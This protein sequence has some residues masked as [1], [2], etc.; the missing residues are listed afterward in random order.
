MMR[1]RCLR[2]LMGTQ[3]LFTA[4][5]PSPPVRVRRASPSSLEVCQPAA[6]DEQR[7]SA[8]LDRDDGAVNSDDANAPWREVWLSPTTADGHDAPPPAASLRRGATV[9]VLPDVAS[10]A[11]RCAL[12]DAAL[13]AT[14]AERAPR[15]AGAL[16][17][18][19]LMRLT[20]DSDLPRDAAAVCDAVLRRVLDRLDAQLPSIAEAY[21]PTDEGEDVPPGFG[22]ES[23]HAAGASRATSGRRRGRS[24]GAMFEADAVEFAFR[25]P[26][27][28]VY[29]AGGEFKPHV[30]G[31]ALTV[32]VPLNA[33]G[34]DYLGGGTGFWWTPPASD[35]SGEE[36]REEE[37][38]T[39]RGTTAPRTAPRPAARSSTAARDKPPTRVLRPPPGTAMVFDGQEV[40]HAGMP[41]ESGTRVLF[42][43]S[44][45]ARGAPE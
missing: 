12:V 35:Q 1:S 22:E 18:A 2:C 13:C 8:I 37:E 44:F 23:A 33:P 41:T 19:T 38:D 34:D 43:A 14:A 4:A 6:A 40:W 45:R 20:R 30:D 26:A 39:R 29:V 5:F 36:L 15:A 24:L 32:L 28:N 9:L 25:E 7:I 16:P 27:V 3:L 17:G 21:F 11:E 31:Q 10:A 42:V